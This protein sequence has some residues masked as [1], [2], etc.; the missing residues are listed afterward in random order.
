[1]VHDPFLC[2]CCD[3]CEIMIIFAVG[4]GN[5]CPVTCYKFYLVMT[6][7]ISKPKNETFTWLQPG[8]WRKPCIV[9][10]TMV[11]NSRQALFGK[12]AHDG[13]KAVVEKT[14]IGWA[15]I[16][17][18]RRLLEMCPEMKILADKVMP[19]HHHM[20]L[21][22]QRTMPRSIREVVRG[23]MQGCKEEARKLGFTENLYD[24]PPFYRVLTHRGQLHAMIEYVK[25]NA[26]RAWLRRQNPDLFRMHRKT[27]VCGLQ[28]TS[29]GNHFLLDWPDRQL[30]E[31][32]RSSSDEQIEKRLKEVMV[33]A[34]NGAV[35]YTAAIS[36]GE[37]IIA[38]SVREHGFP[39]VVLLNNGFP[40]EGASQERF[41]KPGGVY[42]EACSKGRLLLMEPEE[43][44]FV[45]PAVMMATE[46]VLKK[47]AEAK[48]YSYIGVPVK[49][50]R[51]RFVALNEM[52]RILVT[53]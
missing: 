21:Q 16:N 1:M 45:N 35:T 17:Q 22:V 27:E 15:L 10:V 9:H 50:Q 34:H 37:K 18:Q 43:G 6:N 2:F 3:G 38:K 40:A 31:M 28:F 53:R 12:L 52:G 51:Y 47:K 41:Y 25:A 30:V 29:M 39:L 46:D 26:E 20:V 8:A 49:S 11:A 19:D 42:F 13:S 14:P 33:A 5:S 4:N 48:H 7:D 23:Y 24:A 44:T 32:S 36:N